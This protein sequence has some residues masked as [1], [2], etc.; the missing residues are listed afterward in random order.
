MGRLAYVRFAAA[1]AVFDRVDA[2]LGM[3]ISAACFEGPAELLQETRWQ[4]PAVFA[5]SVALYEAWREGVD[6]TIVCAAGHSLGEFGALVAAGA[7]ELEEAAR[8]VALRG[9]LMQEASDSLPGRMSAI[10]GLDRET[11]ATICH[12]ASRP[13]EGLAEIVVL[14]NDNAPEQQVISGGL[15]ALERATVAARA[16][17]ARRVIPLKVAGAFHSPLIESAVERLAE[18][19]DRAPLAR[20]AFPVIANSTCELLSEPA[21]VRAELIRQVTSPVRWVESVQVAAT[22]T[23]EIWIDTGPGNVAA[24]LAGRTL[25]GIE[26]Q[27]LSALIDTEAPS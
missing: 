8:L 16:R 26:T 4:Q 2:A 14:A 10:I 18:A 23:P 17:G 12:E 15:P 19:L 24:G 3:A 25:P 6:D 20:C 5:C 7:L 13:D 1:R 9:S 27:T 22:F 21:A 11:V